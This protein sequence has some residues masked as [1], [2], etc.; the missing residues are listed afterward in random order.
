MENENIPLTAPEAETTA[1]ELLQRFFPTASAPPSL[2]R[3]TDGIT[4]VVLCARFKCQR[5]EGAEENVPERVLIRIYGKNTEVRRK[6]VGFAISRVHF[7]VPYKSTA[8]GVATQR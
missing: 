3:M 7:C 4:N 1:G 5:G 8:I 2:Q 6:R